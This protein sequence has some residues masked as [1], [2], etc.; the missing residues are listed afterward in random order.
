MCTASPNRCA[1]PAA[2][3][4][5]MRNVGGAQMLGAVVDF[6]RR[7]IAAVSAVR[8]SPA[9][10]PA[11]ATMNPSTRRS[12]KRRDALDRLGLTTRYRGSVRDAEACAGMST[13]SEKSR[14]THATLRTVARATPP[15]ST[16]AERSTTLKRSAD[17][18]AAARE[19]E[20]ENLDD[21]KKVTDFPPPSPA[22]LADAA[23]Q[24]AEDVKQ[25]VIDGHK[26]LD[27]WNDVAAIAAAE[28]LL[29]TAYG[30]GLTLTDAQK[31]A[32]ERVKYRVAH[33]S[34]PGYRCFSA[35]VDMIGEAFAKTV[36]AKQRAQAAATRAAAA[37]RELHMPIGEQ[38]PAQPSQISA[39]STPATADDK[40]HSAE[41]K[42]LVAASYQRH[43]RRTPEVKAESPQ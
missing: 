11:P 1:S 14:A 18:A 9:V 36:R 8:S 29:S 41:D 24:L 2:K 32:T 25:I 26:L 22:K 6:I 31:I 42:A 21:E 40:P 38:R 23:L 27:G 19:R 7:V 43:L 3:N 12:H 35:F 30:I 16:R 17:A 10:A 33:G 4:C 28:T 15:S 20:D 34:A 39:R 5:G 37:Q 13:N